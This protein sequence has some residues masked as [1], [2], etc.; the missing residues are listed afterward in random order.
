MPH[1]A[2]AVDI[3]GLGTC[4]V[5]GAIRLEGQGLPLL[6]VVWVQNIQRTTHTYQPIISNP[7]N[8]NHPL[9]RRVSTLQL[10]TTGR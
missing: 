7:T 3:E 8:P 4:N 5:G 2:S 6:Q 9:L 1:K 10:Q